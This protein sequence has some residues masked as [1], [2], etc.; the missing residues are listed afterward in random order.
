MENSVSG[1][2]IFITGA[3][4]GLGKLVAMHLAEQGAHLLI[5]GRNMTKGE[6]V[7]RDLKHRTGNPNIHYYNADF[8]L[9]S[10]VNALGIRLLNEDKRIDILINNAG[11]ALSKREVNTDGIELTLAV[12]YFAQVLLTEKLLAIMSLQSS[13]IINVASAAQRALDFSD[14]MMEKYYES[15]SAYSKSK[16]ALIMY[17]F[18]LAERLKGKGITVNALHPATLMNT[19]MVMDRSYVMSTVE[20]GA[21]AVEGLLKIKETGC[22]YNSKRLSKAIPQVYDVPT[23]RKLWKLT[24]DILTPYLFC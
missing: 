4:D 16:A 14:F 12:N 20:E 9:L 15:F 23:R 6:E 1:K 17:T 11:T 5:H 2:T 19:K 21:S 22:Y 24:N 7:L 10:D 8:S 3:T 18:D 13:K